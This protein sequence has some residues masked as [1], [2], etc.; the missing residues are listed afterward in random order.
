MDFF[1][2][3]III[4]NQICGISN[5][6]YFCLLVYTVRNS[7]NLCELFPNESGKISHFWSNFHAWLLSCKQMI[8]I[9]YTWFNKIKIRISYG[10]V[11]PA[12]CISNELIDNGI[13]IASI[14]IVNKNFIGKLIALTVS[15]VHCAMQI[16]WTRNGI[17]KKRVG[18]F[19]RFVQKIDQ[20]GEKMWARLNEIFWK[21]KFKKRLIC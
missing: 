17:Y 4:Y 7:T 1:Y 21:L 2:I 11:T 8:K 6:P 18:K 19:V 5:Y 16:V 10:K 20:N 12:I 3:N 14:W 13:V 9:D 15:R